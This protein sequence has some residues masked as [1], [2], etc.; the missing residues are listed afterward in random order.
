MCALVVSFL[1]SSLSQEYVC[2][3]DSTANLT[4]DNMI[5]FVPLPAGSQ[6]RTTAAEYNP[7]GLVLWYNLASGVIEAARPGGLPYGE[8]IK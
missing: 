1:S 5:T 6:L 8:Y 2:P 3:T 7:G 4:D